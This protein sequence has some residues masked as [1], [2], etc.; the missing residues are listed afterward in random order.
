MSN[1]IKELLVDVEQT[2]VR[3]RHYLSYWRAGVYVQLWGAVWFCA[4]L[5]SFF[6]PQKAGLIWLACNLAGTLGS[7]WLSLRCRHSLEPGAYAYKGWIAFGLVMLFAVLA[8]TLI[9]KKPAALSV[10]WSCLFMTI[11]MIAGLWLGVRWIVLGA[12][13]AI[14]TILAYLY[15]VPWFNLVMALLGGGGLIV[16]GTWLR[17][18][19]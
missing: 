13:I 19:T 3:T 5:A 12:S 11:Y 18:A 9:G 16:G 7:I 2:E 15:L 1:T 14:I 10:F 6:F 17:K 8:S 4:Y